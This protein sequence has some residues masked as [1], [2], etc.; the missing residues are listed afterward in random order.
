MALNIK[1]LPNFVLTFLLIV[2]IVGVGIVVMTNMGYASSR[3]IAATNDNQTM[4]NTSYVALLNSP[5]VSSESFT[6][7]NI[8]ATVPTT[9]YKV[10]YDLGKVIMINGKWHG[11]QLNASYTYLE[12]TTATTA[13][14]NA[15]NSLGVINNTWI[16]LLVTVT[17]LAIVL[18]LVINAYGGNKR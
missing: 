6:L 13:M 12:T 15:S 2:M 14:N 3:Q 11:Q 7:T 10:D 4:S 5:L 17:L 16:G 9:D 18:G 1:E 8:S